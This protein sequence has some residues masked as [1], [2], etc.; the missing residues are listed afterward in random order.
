MTECNEYQLKV[1][2]ICQEFM[3][4]MIDGKINILND[5]DTDKLKS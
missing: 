2:L 1:G 5:K 3:S 4:A